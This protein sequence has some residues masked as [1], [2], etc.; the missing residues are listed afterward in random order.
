MGGRG[1]AGWDSG[2]ELC[3]FDYAQFPNGGAGGVEGDYLEGDYL[4]GDYLE[5]DYL[6]GDYR[7]RGCAFAAAARV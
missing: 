6:E 1:A 4:E 5:G 7:G 2:D 3:G